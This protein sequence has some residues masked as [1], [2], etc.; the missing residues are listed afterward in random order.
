MQV[1]ISMYR[2]IVLAIATTVLWVATLETKPAQAATFTFYSPGIYPFGLNYF[3]GEDTNANG[4]I[5]LN[6]LSDFFADKRQYWGQFALYDLTDVRSFRYPLGATSGLSYVIG[7]NNPKPELF[8]F[9]GL[10]ASI[11]SPQPPTSV[12]E[13]SATIGLGVISLYG[14]LKKGSYNCD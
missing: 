14:L 1:L 13:A 4:L 5:E 2:K 9:G 7:N 8:G 3:T 10:V 11:P 6:E 12:P